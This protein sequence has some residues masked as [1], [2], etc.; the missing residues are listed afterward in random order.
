MD[1]SITEEHSEYRDSVI[2]FA[3]SELQDDVRTREKT[4]EFFWDGWRK[5][6]EFGIHGLPIPEQYGGVNADITTCV[7]VMDALGYAC[8][9]SGLLFALNSHLWTC[10]IPILEFGTEAQKSHYLPEMAAGKIVGGHAMT[11]PDAGSDAY[12][13]R[14]SAIKDGDD[15]VLN[16]SKTFISNAP[17]A[18]VLLIFATTNPALGWAGIS[19]F[20]VDTEN[21]GLVIGNTLDKVG[22]KT[23]PTAEVSLQDCRVPKS[24]MLGRLGQGSAIFNAEMEWE[25]S[26]LF[27]CHLGAMRAQLE[28]SSE[29]ARSRHQ[30]NQ[31]INS[32]QAVSHKLADMRVRIELAE[33]ILHKV[34]WLKATGQRAQLESA[35]A[36][37]YV[38][39]SYLSSSLDAVQI[40][41]GYGFMSEYEVDRDV[42]DALGARI[43]SGTSEIQKNI[44]ATFLEG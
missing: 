9:D 14:T 3:K 40:H 33:L 20:L 29:Y 21:P 36:K 1:F 15:F 7:H 34:A 37:L 2:R 6:A 39:E 5:C 31:P 38:S 12:S 32:F 43:Y 27:A 26:C 8:R 18:D 41:G 44:I 25:R 22:V 16:G 4:G 17:I 10:A 13:L 24:A 35:I 19:G 30:F 23:S 28:Q 11:E 42:R